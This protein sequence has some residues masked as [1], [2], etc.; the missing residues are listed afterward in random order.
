VLDE[1]TV[2]LRDIIRFT[3]A[4]L[5]TGFNGKDIKQMSGIVCM[6]EPTR[7]VIVDKF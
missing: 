5:E 4:D 1:K 3:L 7:W 6:L 2:R